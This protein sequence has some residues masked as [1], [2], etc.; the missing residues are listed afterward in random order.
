MLLKL[1]SS[2]FGSQSRTRILLAIDLLGSSFPRELSRLLDVPIFAV[3]KALASLERDGILSARAVGRTRVYRFDP[4]YPAHQELVAY[5]TRLARDNPTMRARTD[6]LAQAPDPQVAA[7]SSTPATPFA[8]LPASRVPSVP[9]HKDRAP[10]AQ[11][12]R[13]GGGWKNW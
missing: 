9:S 7:R 4:A 11:P 2:P 5:V 12:G 3:R 8:A 1:S 10:V 13:P 6:A